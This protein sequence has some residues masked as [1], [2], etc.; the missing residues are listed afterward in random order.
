MRLH[1]PSQLILPVEVAIT[2]RHGTGKPA[3]DLVGALVLGQVG[4]LAEPLPTDRALEG[5]QAGVDALVHR[6]RCTHRG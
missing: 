6:W 3:L 5:F 2:T 4:G 1:M